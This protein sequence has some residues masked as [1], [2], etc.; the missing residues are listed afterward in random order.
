[1]DARASALAFATSR[2]AET[3]LAKAASAGVDIACLRVIDQ[4][5]LQSLQ[6]FF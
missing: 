5:K 3:D 4:F 2:I 6:R 1:M